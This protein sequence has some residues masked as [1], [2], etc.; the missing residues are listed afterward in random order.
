V[1][2]LFHHDNP[3]NFDPV[4]WTGNKYSGDF[5]QVRVVRVVR[6]EVGGRRSSIE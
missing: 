3:Q 6:V 5:G 1:G 4:S 2:K